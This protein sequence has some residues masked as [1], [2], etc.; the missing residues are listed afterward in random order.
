M[1]G[2]NFR[3]NLLV[4]TAKL[5]TIVVTELLEPTVVPV[6]NG[7]SPTHAFAYHCIDQIYDL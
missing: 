1:L 3:V 6:L 5:L 2:A 4:V 7:Y